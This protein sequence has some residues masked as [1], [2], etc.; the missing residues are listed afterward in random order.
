[1]KLHHI[2]GLSFLI[3][4]QTALAASL[5]CTNVISQPSQDWINAQSQKQG[6]STIVIVH[7]IALYGKCIDKNTQELHAKMIKSGKYPLMGAKGNFQDFTD[8]LQNFTQLALKT[9]ATGG[10]WDNI[11]AAYTQLY[12]KQFTYLFYAPFLEK[13]SD[14]ILTRL[15]NT[16]RPDLQSTKAYFEKI[17]GRFT[18]TQQA[19]LR[20]SFSE[21]LNLAQENRFKE[22]YVYNYAIYILQPISDPMFS[23]PPF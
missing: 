7:T 3:F 19:V 15:Q 14:P 12:Q 11:Q 2:I 9:T 22:E 18:P 16:K 13:N 4:F 6:S 20:T 21:L 10:T 23:P 1:M 17:L 5:D 8:A